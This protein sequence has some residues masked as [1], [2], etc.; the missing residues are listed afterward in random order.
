[1]FSNCTRLT[2]LD[3][4]EWEVTHVT[5]MAYLFNGCKKLTSL[6]MTK[7]NTWRVTN[8]MYMMNGCTG[9]TSLDL[10]N[11]NTERVTSSH[12]LL[13]GCTNLSSLTVSKSMENIS[14]YAFDGV[15][16]ETAPCKLDM[17]DGFAFPEEVDP[18][19]DVFEWGMGFFT[20]ANPYEL[21]DVNIDRA[22]SIS[23]VMLTISNVISGNLTGF[24]KKNAD[25]NF[26]GVISISDVML[27]LDKLFAR[28]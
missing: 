2:N 6:D 28:E 27:I 22:I 17:P 20:L 26:D 16:T 24:H 10:S 18:V 19:E 5:N 4:S 8:M 13:G 23:D 1:M 9:L 15:G 25:M 21:G 3:V 11:L 12:Y 14:E 7:W